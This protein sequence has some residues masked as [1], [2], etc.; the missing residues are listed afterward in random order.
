MTSPERT[1]SDGVRAARALLSLVEEH[2]AEDFHAAEAILG[3]QKELAQVLQLLRD[4]KRQQ[5]PED[6]EPVSFEGLREIVRKELI[7]LARA[8]AGVES[9]LSKSFKQLVGTPPKST[10]EDTVEQIFLHLDKS[11]TH[12]QKMSAPADLLR[13]ASLVA[14]LA[15]RERIESLLRRLA[16]SALAENVI[17]LP[18]LHSIAQL[19]LMWA[20]RPLPY[21]PHESRQHLAERLMKDV[22]QHAPDDIGKFAILLLS[23]GLRGPADRAIAETR[24]SDVKK[25]HGE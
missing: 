6:Q 25:A 2:S 13:R 7:E 20:P 5:S 19:R 10:I 4:F 17:S 8:N 15:H 12:F 3:G 9:M 1:G 18:T 22:E 24:R 21:K 11:P 14:G 16:I 23:E